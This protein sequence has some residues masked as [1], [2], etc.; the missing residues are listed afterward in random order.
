MDRH[1]SKIYYD[2]NNPAGFSS[3]KKLHI[4]LNGKYTIGE[5]R[6]WIEAQ[7]TYT[8]HRNRRKK[9][10]RNRFF[11][12]NID[13]IWQADLIDMR[14]LKKF[15]DNFNYMLTVIDTFS[16][17]AWVSPLIT[18]SGREV[19]EAFSKIIE[20]S[21]RKPLKL[22]CDKANNPDTKS[23]IVE[24]WNRTLKSK[25][26]KY[27]TYKNS[28]RYIDAVQ[29]MVKSYNESRHSSTKFAPI[30]V[31]E[32][33]VLEVFRN[34]Y[35]NESF[36]NHNTPKFH[37]DDRVRISREKHVFEKGYVTNFS[38]EIF[39]IHKIL[40]RIP[41]V[42]VITDL[43][44]DVIEGTFYEYELQKVNINNDKAF[45][46]D[47]ILATKGKGVSRKHLIRWLGYPSQFDSWYCVAMKDNFYLTLPS[48]SSFD[49]F[50]DNKTSC[51]T[52]HLP[53]RIS[54]QGQY[55]VAVVEC[56]FP[57]TFANINNTNNIIYYGRKNKHM[58]KF[59]LPIGYYSITDIIKKINSHQDLSNFLEL[60]FIDGRI[61]TFP[62]GEGKNPI[63]RAH[64]E[65]GY[66]IDQVSL[67]GN[68][69]MQLGFQ[70]NVNLMDTQISE[71]EP[72]VV[73]GLPSQIYLY[74]DIVEQQYIGDTLAQLLRIIHMDNLNYIFGTDM[75]AHFE[76]PHYIPL[77][78]SE[79]ET[80]EIDLRTDRG[81]PVPFIFGTACIKLHFRR[82]TEGMYANDPYTSYYLN[83]AGSGI[84]QVY[85]GAPF[86]KGHGIGNFLSGI[87]RSF[88][89]LL[90][91]G[92]K[93]IGTELLRTG[94]NILHDV[95]MENNP[96]ESV[97]KRSY[98]AAQNMSEKLQHKLK[99]MSGQGYKKRKLAAKGQSAGRTGRRKVHIKKKAG[100]YSRQ[101][102]LHD[103]FS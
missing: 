37:I 10:P 34:L 17:Y 21:G 30:E 64:A 6:K 57:R 84:S 85:N 28:F 7:D 93:S 31:K 72:T 32:T 9:F 14:C 68:L 89:P 23:M 82:C 95:A 98:E 8:L 38:E 99:T 35:N 102:K 49:A 20:S 11:V 80:I 103:I 76:S 59:K 53:Q 96:R 67:S 24:R 83:Q 70:I 27:F 58:K 87:F 90:K 61:K 36:M 16:K 101:P 65:G 4:S 100:K 60:K 66:S 25:M 97:R 92:A 86:Q 74:C 26:W 40:Y 88:V 77:K 15:N 3:V 46:I 75:V 18:K 79:F 48:N 51:F 69:A 5:I 78:K 55:E 45:K 33:N 41:I 12:T 44:G 39:K 19:T 13:E 91:S 47:K 50:P 63:L 94:G 56:H 43:N 29:H 62:S 71:R 1:L 22:N 54:L 81:S 73:L 2:I 52:T 42:Y